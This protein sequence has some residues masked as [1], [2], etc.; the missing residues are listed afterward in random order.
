MQA[1]APFYESKLKAAGIRSTTKLLERAATPKLRKELAEATNIPMRLILDWANIADLTRVTG[2]A[3]DYA[4]LLFAA[5]VNTVKDLGRRNAA[6]LVARMAE[7]NARSKRGRAAAAARSAW[8]AGSK[9]RRR[10]RPGCNTS[11]ARVAGT[12]V[13]ATVRRTYKSAHGRDRKLLHSAPPSRVDIRHGRWRQ[14]GRRAPERPRFRQPPR[15][16]P[17]RHPDRAALRAAQRAVRARPAAAQARWIVVQEIELPIPTARMSGSGQ[18]SKAA[19]T[20]FRCAFRR[21]RRRNGFPACLPPGAARGIRWRRPRDD[22]P[23]DRRRAAGPASRRSARQLHRR[24]AASRR[25]WPTSRSAS[26]LL[27]RLPSTA[28]RPIPSLSRHPSSRFT[29]AHFRGPLAVLDAR[30]FHEAGATEAQELA[31]VLARRRGGSAPSRPVSQPER[32]P[33]LLGASISVD[34]M[35]SCRSRSCVPCGFSGRVSRKL[36]DVAATPLKVHAETSRRMLTRDELPT[37]SCATR[38]PPS[39]PASAARTPSLVVP[40]TAA[41]AWPTATRAR[42]HATSSTS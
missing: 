23:A 13:A 35:C 14:T 15:S 33:A 6:T 5:G 3:L 25:S 37:I 21:L 31:A 11:T 9:L 8:R 7:M 34:A 10:S 27:P 26:T 36:C 19:R 41:S 4:E 1:I 38:S 40:H 16:H 32:S 39:R 17:R 30:S 24:R 2:I 12:A 20:D 18:T 22:P 29:G 28:P 42:S